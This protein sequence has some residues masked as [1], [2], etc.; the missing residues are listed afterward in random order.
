MGIAN[1]VN[2]RRP[3]NKTE[4]QNTTLEEVHPEKTKSNNFFINLNI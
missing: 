4:E 2:T 1:D 3:Q